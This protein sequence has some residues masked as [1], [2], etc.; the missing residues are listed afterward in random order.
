MARIKNQF[1]DMDDASMKATL[2]EYEQWR[3]EGIIPS[4]GSLAK[5]RDKYRAAYAA[6]GLT[7][8]ET[9]LLFAGTMRW[10]SVVS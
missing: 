6:H 4:G 8:M 3:K 5:A 2:K 7:I 1:I 10:L 9:D